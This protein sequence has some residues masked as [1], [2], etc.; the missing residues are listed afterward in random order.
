MLLSPRYQHSYGTICGVTFNDNLGNY[1]Q[2]GSASGAGGSV[3]G[4][5]GGGGSLVALLAGSIGRRFGIPGIIIAGL[6]VFFFNGGTNMFSSTTHN[7][8]PQ[9]QNL[10]HCVT[11]DDANTYDDCRI[12]AAG[13]ALDAFWEEALPANENIAYTKPQLVIGSGQLSTGCGASDISQTG[14]FY[15]PGD[16]T[17]YMAVPFFERLKQM[18]GSDGEFAQLYVVAH[19]FGH[20]IQ[21]QQ[22]TLSLSNYNDPGQGSNAVKIELQAD[23]YAGMWAAHADKGADAMLDPITQSQVQQAITTARAIG[24]DAIQSSAGQRVNPDLWTHGSSQQRIDSFLRGYQG[25]TM[26]SCRQSFNR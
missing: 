23:C 13:V 20:H 11:A 22:G 26:D 7:A 1:S 10:D 16:Q 24:D 4:R 6:A 17:V 2:R 8:V 12:L 25:A 14:P 3:G 15:C 5:G 9:G 19:E 21:D 18:G